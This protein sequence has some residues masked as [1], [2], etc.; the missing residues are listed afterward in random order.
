MAAKVEA[1]LCPAKEFLTYGVRAI[2]SRDVGDLD[3]F[4]G[5]ASQ[6]PAHAQGRTN[7][8]PGAGG[9][10]PLAQGTGPADTHGPLRTRGSTRLKASDRKPP[11][12][13]PW[14]APPEQSG[15]PGCPLAWELPSSNSSPEPQKPPRKAAL[16][17]EKPPESPGQ[18][19]SPRISR[20]VCRRSRPAWA[21]S[22][23][24]T[25]TPSISKRTKPA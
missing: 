18:T 23:P 24:R 16:K 10:K 12:P 9:M 3:Q 7:N 4:T 14:P 2:A 20:S 21:E 25:I 22:A 8:T 15:T 6:D 11:W 5:T 13:A 1:A 19:I 17:Q